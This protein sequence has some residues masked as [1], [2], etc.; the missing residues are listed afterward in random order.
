MY[1]HALTNPVAGAGS[2]VRKFTPSKRLKAAHRKYGG[3]S[4]LTAFARS[5]ATPKLAGFPT[6][7]DGAAMQAAIAWLK[8]KGR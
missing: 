4:T 2:H 5:E 3:T 1:P 8:N 6:A 7:P